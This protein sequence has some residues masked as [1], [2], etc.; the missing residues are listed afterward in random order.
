MATYDNAKFHLDGASR[1]ESAYIHI[2]FFLGWAVQRGF[3]GELLKNDSELSQLLERFRRRE[4]TGP[5]LLEQAVDGVLDDQSLN[6]EGCRFADYYYTT[7]RWLPSYYHDYREIF[8]EFRGRVAPPSA[9]TSDN[10]EKMARRIDTVYE[11]WVRLGRPLKP[12]RKKPWW[13]IL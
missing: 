11:E 12:V 10:F 2:G 13:K 6:P 9:D 5:Q 3:A 4:V 7:G 8:P 1:G